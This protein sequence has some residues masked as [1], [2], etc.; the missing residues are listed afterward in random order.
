MVMGGIGTDSG[1]TAMLIV[2][3]PHRATLLGVVAI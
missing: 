3:S 2:H 1:L